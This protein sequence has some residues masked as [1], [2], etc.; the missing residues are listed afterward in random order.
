MYKF[1]LSKEMQFFVF[2]LNNYAIQKGL[3]P[4]TVYD[5]FKEGGLLEYVNE[6]YF[7]YHQESISNAFLDMDAI[8]ENGQSIHGWKVK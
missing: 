5:N 8:L 3:S 2:L 4:K 7:I 1:N 6:M